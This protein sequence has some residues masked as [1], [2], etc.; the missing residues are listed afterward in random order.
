MPQE[1]R[2]KALTEKVRMGELFTVDC[3]S[4]GVLKHVSS[5]WG[6]L[7]LISLREGTLRFGELRRKASGVSEKML[8]QTL[9]RLEEDGFVLRFSHQVVP[10]YVEYSLTPLGREVSEQVA[11]LA[12]WIELNISSVMDSRREKGIA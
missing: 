9:K 12:D 11:T 5:L 2:S 3:P 4:R 8:A 6:V 10:P 1:A 7:C